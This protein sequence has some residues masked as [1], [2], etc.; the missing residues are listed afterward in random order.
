MTFSPV[1][2]PCRPTA[3]GRPA[4][5]FQTWFPSC[6]LSPPG[7]RMAEGPS[8]S[9]LPPAPPRPEQKAGRQAGAGETTAPVSQAGSLRGVAPRSTWGADPGPSSI[10]APHAHPVCP[11]HFLK[12]QAGPVRAAQ[13]ARSGPQFLLQV[14]VWCP[15]RELV[16][17]GRG[18]WGTSPRDSLSA[19]GRCLVGGRCLPP[20]TCAAEGQ[21]SKEEAAQ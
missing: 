16:A 14:W 20:R 7:T 6:R 18:V 10:L 3:C 2:D 13:M 11:N 4:P 15:A 1:P 9:S 19:G 5:G 17:Q 12:T 21:T 8:S